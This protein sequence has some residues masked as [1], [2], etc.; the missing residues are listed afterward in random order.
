MNELIGSTRVAAQGREIR[1]ERHFN[2]P[3]ARVFEAWTTPEHLKQWWGPRAFPTTYCTVDF[4]VGG[5]WHYCMT[6]PNGEEAW[7][8]ATYLEIVVPERIVYSDAFSDAQGGVNP[9]LPSMTIRIDFIETPAGTTVV[10]TSQASSAE[11][12][13]RLLEMG[14]AQGIA[15]TWDRLDEFL[16]K[17]SA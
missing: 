13:K 7:G 16:Q 9:D 11:D 15:E 12:V 17:P 14:M 2:A 10:S 8:N 4:R 6:G 1:V 5:N 3:R